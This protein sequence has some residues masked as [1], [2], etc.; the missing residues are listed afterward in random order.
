VRGFRF[1]V[2]ATAVA[3]GVLLVPARAA[4]HTLLADVVVAAEVKLL[5]YFDD[6]VPARSAEVVVADPGGTAVLT[7]KTD[8]RGVWTFPR[9][10]PGAYLLT[11]TASGHSARVPFAVA[12]D[13][14]APAVAYTGPRPN[15]ALGLAL[16][17]AGLFGFSAL[18]WFFRR[19]R[20]L[21]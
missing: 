18:F 16:G 12:A 9:P 21:Q 13:P 14:D 1:L 3:G 11:V 5:A 8:A 20:K 6:D 2:L 19:R 17:V 10:A 15:R 4:A 7:G